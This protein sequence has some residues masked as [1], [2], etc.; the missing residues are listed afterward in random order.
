MN[1]SDLTGRGSFDPIVPD[2][3][4]VLLLL[5]GALIFIWDLLDRR[6]QKIRKSGGLDE[7]AE[8][9]A[10]RGS[11]Y[12]RVK[13]YYSE[14]LGLSSRPHG[15]IREDGAIIPVDIYPATNK[16]KDRHIAQM[17]IHLKVIEE[18][19]KHKPPYG[20]LVM[21]PEARSVKIKY[22]EEKQR[23]ISDIVKEMRDIIEGTPAVP[24]PSFYKCKNCDVREQ[25]VYTAYHEEDEKREKSKKPRKEEEA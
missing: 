4:L 11:A 8:I 23:W 2:E 25:C 15:L 19:E 16:I 9:V 18:V 21:G 3:I 17:M 13:D 24:A 10:L 22:T 12:L 20:V 1:F 6:S 14:E 5:V 7:K